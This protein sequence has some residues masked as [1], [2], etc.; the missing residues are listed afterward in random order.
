MRE[1][2]LEFLVLQKKLMQTLEQQY[3]QTVDDLLLGSPKQGFIVVG[4]DRWNFYKHG[5]GF[6]F[7]REKDALDIDVHDYIRN[8]DYFDEWRLNLYLTSLGKDGEEQA[9][10][11]IATLLD[12]GDIKPVPEAPEVYH[13][14]EH[15]AK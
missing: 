2:L 8:P 9:K 5:V 1:L 10:S 14:S 3:S 4:G 7:K 6:S 15:N 11:M 12:Q 13:L